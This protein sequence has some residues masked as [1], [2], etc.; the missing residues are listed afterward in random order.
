MRRQ[1]EV[2]SSETLREATFLIDQG[3]LERV[4]RGVGTSVLR[5]L[6]AKLLSPPEKVTVQ[7][8]P[9]AAGPH[10]ALSSFY[11]YDFDSRKIPCGV[12]VEGSITA[13]DVVATGGENV[14]RYAQLWSGLR[15]MALSPEETRELLR[16]K[17]KGVYEDD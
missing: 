4:P 9:F 1:W 13:R 8:V 16:E 2:F 15:A 6:Y 3:A 14:S 10:A 11:L 12:F 7:V 17:M 5:S